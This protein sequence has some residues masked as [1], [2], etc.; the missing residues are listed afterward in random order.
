VVHAVRKITDV[1][2]GNFIMMFV[3]DISPQ[4]V[5]GQWQEPVGVGNQPGYASLVER[6]TNGRFVATVM[7]HEL[8]H[9]LGL[10]HLAGTIMNESADFNPNNNNLSISPRQLKQLWDWILP[11]NTGSFQNDLG[12]HQ[13]EMNDFLHAHTNN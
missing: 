2:G 11:F 12:A 1:K 5:Q 9:N 10:E 3:D 7:V 6:K 4:M 8:G 13:D